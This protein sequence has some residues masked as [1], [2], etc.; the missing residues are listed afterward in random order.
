MITSRMKRT[1]ITPISLLSPKKL[2][3]IS[4]FADYPFIYEVVSLTLSLYALSRRYA[5]AP[6]HAVVS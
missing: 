3:P 1:K 2:M 6:A 5:C 4:P